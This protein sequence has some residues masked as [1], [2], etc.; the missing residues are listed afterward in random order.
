[1]SNIYPWIF[2]IDNNIWKVYLTDTDVLMYQSMYEEKKWTKEKLIDVGVIEFAASV[3][4]DTI[5]I[6]YVNKKYEMRYCTMKDGKWFGKLLYHIDMRQFKI[7]SLKAVILGGKLNFFYL[8]KAS[9][10]SKHGILKHYIWD[11]KEI[12]FYT[13]QHVILSDKIDKYY[14]IEIGEDDCINAFSLSDRGDEISLIYCKY[15]GNSWTSD[16]RLYGLQ[17]DNILFDVVGQGNTFNIINRSKED[18]MYLLEHVCIEDSIYMKKYEVYKSKIEPIEPI[19]FYRDGK[20]FTCWQEYNNIFC[21]S[22][23]FGKW[24]NRTLFNEG[25]KTPIEIYNF[26][27]LKESIKPHIV[28]GAEND[29][30]YIFPLSDIAESNINSL[31][32]KAVNDK[33]NINQED[34]SIEEIKEKFKNICYENIILKEKIDSF[35]M[36]LQKK[37][38]ITDEYE[39]KISKIVEQKRR[40][41]ENLNFFMEVKKNIEKQMDEIKRQFS[42]QQIIAKSVQ[43]KL[44]EKEKNNEL[45]KGKVDYL[46]KENE[47]LKNQLEIERNQ[48]FMAKLFGKRDRGL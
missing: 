4:D 37:K 41:E 46:M 26:V 36:H 20:L 48:S 3:E 40:L 27:N 28:Y 13:I 2:N 39:N 32:N 44:E 11:G 5:H 24:S 18:S 12:K 8:L 35:S 33:S 42:N 29:G 22:Y 30:L 23:I 1:M 9:D 19:I 14:E 17:G 21:A 15:D 43:D 16:K 45:L 7:E 47:K 6:V 25:L 34:E 31:K 38:H 10:D